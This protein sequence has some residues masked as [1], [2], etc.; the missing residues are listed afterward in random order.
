MLTTPEH[1][2]IHALNKAMTVEEVVR[3]AHTHLAKPFGAQAMMIAAV[4]DDRIWVVGHRGQSIGYVRSLHAARVADHTLVADAVEGRA[5]FVPDRSRLQSPYRGEMDDLHQAWALLPLVGSNY[6]VGFLSLGFSK[7]RRFS[8]D[9]EEDLKLMADHLASTLERVLVCR[10]LHGLAESLQRSLLPRTLAALPGAV[11]AARYLP[12]PAAAGVGGDWYDVVAL[13]NERI[14]L[15][16]GDV[17]GHNVQSAAVMGQMRSAILAYITEGHTVEATLT[18]A[19][20]L[21]GRLD[22]SLLVTC[23]ITILDQREGTLEIASAGHLTPLVRTHDEVSIQLD[24][25][26]GPPLGVAPSAAYTGVQAVLPVGALLLLYTNGLY[27]PAHH[28]AVSRADALVR[29]AS[30]VAGKDPEEMSDRMI[31]EISSQ[32]T[33]G[34]DV[35]LLLARYLG[36]EHRGHRVNRLIIPRHDLHGVRRARRFTKHTLQNWGV[37]AASD[38]MELIVAEVVTNALIHADT[39][40]D[41]RLREHPHWIRVEVRDSAARPPIPSALSLSPE[42]RDKVEQGRGLMIVEELASAWGT[43]PNGLGKTVWVEVRT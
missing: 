1:S 29:H 22:T 42:E 2:F 38:N 13:E 31:A 12:A 36:P 19:N 20:T 7:P 25:A 26:T 8:S 34:D 27:D 4:Q 32:S 9:E 28:D 43:S 18:R 33:R 3:Q 24:I 30:S 15:V 39:D 6:A 21:L 40:V 37:A 5:L 10:N 17:E 23:C 41:V 14:C 11:V 35:C 16:I